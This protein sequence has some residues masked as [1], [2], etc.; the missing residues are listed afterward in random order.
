MKTTYVEKIV[1]ELNIVVNPMVEPY[2]QAQPPPPA[3]GALV[4]ASNVISSTVLKQ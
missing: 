4:A 2:Q 3:S 1:K